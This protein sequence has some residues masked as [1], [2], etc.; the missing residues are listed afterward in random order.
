METNTAQ[1]NDSGNSEFKGMKNCEGDERDEG[2]GE[3]EPDMFDLLCSR[4]PGESDFYRFY[5]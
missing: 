2:T 3:V 1:G 4:N 5:I